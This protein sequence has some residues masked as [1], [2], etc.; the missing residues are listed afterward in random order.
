MPSRRHELKHGPIGLDKLGTR[1]RNSRHHARRVTWHRGSWVCDR[2]AVL[3]RTSCRPRAASPGHLR[4]AYDGLRSRVDAATVGSASASAPLA[5]SRA[6][7]Y[8]RGSA[9]RWCRDL[10]AKCAA[11]RGCACGA[12]GLFHSRCPVPGVSGRRREGDQGARPTPPCTADVESQRPRVWRDCPAHPDGCGDEPGLA[13]Q[14]HLCSARLVVMV[15]AAGDRLALAA[16]CRP[17]CLTMEFDGRTSAPS[18]ATSVD[19]GHAGAERR[20]VASLKFMLRSASVARGPALKRRGGEMRFSDSAAARSWTRPPR[21]PCPRQ[22]PDSNG[23]HDQ[24]KRCK[25]V[26]STRPPFEQDR[27]DVIG[28]EPAGLRRT[29]RHALDRL[30]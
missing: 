28:I 13:V 29:N 26:G 24:R 25:D 18:S 22:Y 17:S 4:D 3:A 30:L 1:T 14:S 21:P 9:A 2:R 23:Q 10:I 11:K 8:R 19:R 15:S 5:S 6:G 12:A 20:R 16:P 7:A 27:L